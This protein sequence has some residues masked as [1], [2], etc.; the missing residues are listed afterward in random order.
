MKNE[1]LSIIILTN[2]S[3]LSLHHALD[4]ASFAD[5]LVVIDDTSTDNSKEIAEKAGAKVV[6]YTN[7]SFAKK[8]NYGL[9]RANNEWVLYLDADEV[10]PDALRKEIRK[11]INDGIPGVF[12]VV[13]ENYFL[14][15]RMYPDSVERLF[16]RSK[17]KEWVGEVHETAIYEGEAQVL[18]NPLKHYTHTDITSMLAKTNEWSEIEADLRIKANHPPVQWWRLVRMAVSTGWYQF[19]S[20]RLL[21]YGRAGLFEGYFQIVDK[22][23]MYTKLWERQQKIEQ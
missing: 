6:E 23:I 22:L 19:V 1:K 12:K 16:H 2:N 9:K 18:K 8:R 5:E 7:T 14:G 21:K 15:S 20:L 13:R 3:A 11:I 17:L 10:I 4:S